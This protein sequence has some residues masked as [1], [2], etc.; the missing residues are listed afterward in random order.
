MIAA[1]SAIVANAVTLTD[2][3]APACGC[4][5]M[6]ACHMPPMPEDEACCAKI[7]NHYH[8]HYQ[9][10]CPSEE[11]TEATLN[12][13]CD[14]ESIIYNE[15]DVACVCDPTSA[16][17]DETDLRCQLPFQCYE[18]ISV[19]EA[20]NIGPPLTVADILEGSYALF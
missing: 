9:C 12:P 10:E 16:L 4:P 14:P 11:P 20:G 3:E 6:P 8:Y 2:E 1:F 13:V 5:E 19:L 15:T 7:R 18:D 17:Y